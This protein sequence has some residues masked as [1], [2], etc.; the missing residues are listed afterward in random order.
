MRRRLGLPVHAETEN[1]MNVVARTQDG[2]VSLLVDEIGDVLDSHAA[3]FNPLEQLDWV[4]QRTDWRNF[5]AEG[6]VMLV[7]DTDKKRPGSRWKPRTPGKRN[8]GDG[9]SFLHAQDRAGRCAVVAD[10]GE[11]AI[12]C[13]FDGDGRDA[14]GDVGA[15]GGG[16]GGLSGLIRGWA[17]EHHHLRGSRARGRGSQ[18]EW[19]EFEEVAAVHEGPCILKA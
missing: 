16:L 5:Q 9:L 7:L 18:C 15:G 6:P 12:G 1:S 11:D 4:A 13:E 14:E 17:G 2:P 10:G 3:S 19:A 8:D